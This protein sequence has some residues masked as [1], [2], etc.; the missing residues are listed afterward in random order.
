ME[1]EAKSLLITFGSMQASE[2]RLLIKN[3]NRLCW[4]PLLGMEHLIGSCYSRMLDPL[5]KKLGSVI[6]PP[7]QMQL[8]NLISGLSL[9]HM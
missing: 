4:V 2:L 3:E 6:H 9:S 1:E 7:I 8:N 5:I